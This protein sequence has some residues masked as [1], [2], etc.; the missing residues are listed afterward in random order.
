MEQHMQSCIYRYMYLMEVAN[1]K[2]ISVE[3]STL[4]WEKDNSFSYYKI[5]W[6]LF[7][8]GILQSITNEDIAVYLAHKRACKIQSFKDNFSYSAVMQGKLL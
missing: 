8:L 3:L 2:W 7:P 6:D 5:Y 1:V 4:C